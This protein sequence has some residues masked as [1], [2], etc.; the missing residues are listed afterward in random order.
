MAEIKTIYLSAIEGPIVLLINSIP[1]VLFAV[2]N[3]Q[4][5]IGCSK[6]LTKVSVFELEKQLGETAKFTSK[7]VTATPTSRFGW[8]WFTPLLKNIKQH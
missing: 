1:T 7:R 4:A 5:I 3:K 2:K 6:G 8:N